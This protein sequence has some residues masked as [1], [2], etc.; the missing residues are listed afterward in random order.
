MASGAKARF[1]KRAA[2]AVY[3]WTEPRWSLVYRRALQ[4]VDAVCYLS[5]PSAYCRGKVIVWQ[6]V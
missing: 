5:T 2:K 4:D 6:G 1:L 3:P